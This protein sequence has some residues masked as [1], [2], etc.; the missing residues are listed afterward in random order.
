MKITKVAK[1]YS[2]TIPTGD[3]ASK[4]ILVA[5]EAELTKGEKVMDVAKQLDR[6]LQVMMNDSV[7]NLK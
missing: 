2:R 5:L 3:Y 1:S 7:K 6:G 4:K